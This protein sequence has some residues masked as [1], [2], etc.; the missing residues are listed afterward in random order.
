MARP[1]RIARG[2]EDV[3]EHDEGEPAV[4]GAERLQ[5]PEH[6]R[7]G[8]CAVGRTAREH[9]GPGLERA[10]PHLVA[11]AQFTAADLATVLEQPQR[12]APVSRLDLRR[13]EQ[14]VRE[15]DE[16]LVLRALE[17]LERASRVAT[18]EARLVAT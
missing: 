16:G 7:G 12:L 10:E 8:T 5:R 9:E 3:G 13:R 6:A 2:R 18:G 14:V 17:D 1:V 4:A 11:R 15:R